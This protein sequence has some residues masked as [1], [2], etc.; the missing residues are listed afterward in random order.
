[1]TGNHTVVRLPVHPGVCHRVLSVRRSAGAGR[2][3]W[4]L[5]WLIGFPVLLAFLALHL[6]SCTF[7]ADQGH[8]HP[9]QPAVAATDG[10]HGPSPSAP[11]GECDHQQHDDPG[12]ATCLVIP[13]QSNPLTVGIFALPAALTVAP[14]ETADAKTA[15]PGPLGKGA[16]SEPCAGRDLLISLNVART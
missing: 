2:H 1:M 3:G 9:D 10:D 6:A 8:D 7:T 13:R 14:L 4:A 16:P 5:R 11:G 12:D 15:S